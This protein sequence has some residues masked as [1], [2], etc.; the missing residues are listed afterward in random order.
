[1]SILRKTIGFACLV[2]TGML[3]SFATVG[4]EKTNYSWKGYPE[5]A[6]KPSETTLLIERTVPATVRPNK[7]YSYEIKLTNRSF[8]KLDEIILMEKL[9]PNFKMTSAFPVPKKRGNV[10]M[11]NFGY[12]APEQKEIIT[13]TGFAPKTGKVVHRGNADLNFRLGQMNAIMEVVNPSLVFTIE[14]PKSVIITERFPINL[15]FRNNGT[16]TV[17]DAVLEHTLDG[18][19]TAKGNNKIKIDIG[20]LQPGDSRNF[21]LSLAAPKTGVFTNNFV[22]KAKDGVKASKSMKI[23]VK[24]P[25]L[26]IAG[27]APKM[28]YVG[29]KIDYSIKIKNI[30][31]GVAKKLVASLKL[32]AGTKFDSADEGGQ[33]IGNAVIWN[34]GSMNPGESKAFTVNVL[35]QKIMKVSA[36]A[37]AKAFAATPVSTSFITDVQGIPALLLVVDDV[38][39]PVAVGKTETYKVIVKN[40]G[41]LAATGV[42]VQCKLEETMALV[43]SAGPTKAI[44]NEGGVVTFAPL[45]S[46]G[47]NET[48]TWVLTVEAKKAGDVRFGASVKCNQLQRPVAEAESTEFYE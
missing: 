3:V 42:K 17:L 45:K 19:R 41:S 12:M 47:I 35:A 7:E 10:L 34:I 23:M 21:Q 16:A 25:K 44:S 2:A 37:S 8:Y 14:A 6:K 5:T 4:A 33:S 28:R 38:N 9:P 36:S 24:Q 29:N 31:D 48:A 26:Q 43:N 20:D 1:M 32:P 39:D 22:A 40:Q 11:W 46:L 27:N 18:L 30:G 15:S 13:I